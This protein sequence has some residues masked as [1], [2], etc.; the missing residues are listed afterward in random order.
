MLESS[1]AGAT[2]QTG[3]LRREFKFG[4]AM[5]LAFT[6]ISPIVALYVVFSLALQSGGGAAWWGFVICVLF[7]L[8]VAF[9]FAELVSKWPLAG[10]IYQWTRKLAGETV[11]WYAGWVYCC[12]LIIGLAL[13]CYGTGLY[14]AAAFGVDA[15]SPLLSN[16]LAIGVMLFSTLANTVGRKMVKFLMFSALLAEMIGSLGV[17]SYLL[18]FHR[19]NDISIIFS[20]S[21]TSHSAFYV[22]SPAFSTVM[23]VIG[24]SFFGFESA[25]SIAEEVR[26][27]GRAAPKALIL[28]L[29]VVGCVVSYSALALILATP[30]MG[31]VVTGA[32]SD[33]LVATLTNA[34]G[35]V[36]VRPLLLVFAVAF[37]AASVAIQAGASRVLFG[38]AREDALPFSRTLSRL[39]LNDGLPLN[40]IYLIGF[41]V[42]LIFVFSGPGVFATLIS[43]CTA[44]FF[45]SFMFPTFAALVYRL[46][47]A[48]VPGEF[49]AGRFGLPNNILAAVWLVA[50]SV[51]VGWPRTPDSAWYENWS[52]PLGGVAVLLAGSVAYLFCRRRLK[53]AQQPQPVLSEASND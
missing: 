3:T 53:F 50:A 36:V 38:L 33:P 5:A 35:P 46:R 32:V 6:F 41:F 39:S 21:G 34:F 40:A 43:F 44:G 20:S 17:G 16:A 2:Q 25:G 28:S 14:L 51:N 8:S 18:L 49:S 42:A 47:N 29:V 48:W 23:A 15:P 22:L 37:T 11:G 52:V 1:T 12:T 9:V 30:D 24:F 19:V 13:V 26:D 45:L 10:G 7:Q 4:S 27:P 31:A